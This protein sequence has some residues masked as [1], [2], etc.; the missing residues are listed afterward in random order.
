MFKYWYPEYYTK[1]GDNLNKADI[2][3]ETERLKEINKYPNNKNLSSKDSKDLG[4]YNGL[5]VEESYHCSD[6]CP[7][8]GSL[9]IIYKDIIEDKCSAIGGRPISDAAWGGVHRLLPDKRF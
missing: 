3:A 2:I 7:D 4:I 1:R 6:V 9:I 5:E 8:Y